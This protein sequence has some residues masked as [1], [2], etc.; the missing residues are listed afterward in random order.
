MVAR[1]ISEEGESLLVMSWN[2]YIIICNNM[3][4]HRTRREDKLV[5]ES[6][7]N[8]VNLLYDKSLKAQPYIVSGG[9]GTGC[10]L[11]ENG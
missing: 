7:I 6:G 9:T 8:P 4:T 1:Q 5:R 11:I 3:T 10:F 2:R